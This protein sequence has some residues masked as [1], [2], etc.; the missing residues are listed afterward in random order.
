MKADADLLTPVVDL[1]RRGLFLQAYAASEP[2]GPPESWEGTEARIWAG[3]LAN[4]L[5][6]PQLGRVLH[7]LAWRDD[8]DNC[9]ARYFYA[10]SIFH[11]RGPWAAW[12]RMRRMSPLTNATST[13]LADWCALEAHL[14]AIFR[15]FQKADW[16]IAEAIDLAPDRAWVWIER[17]VVLDAE[18]RRDEALQSAERALELRPWY[19]AGVQATAHYLLQVN[20]DEE[21]LE[22]LRQAAQ[23]LECGDVVAHLASLETELGHFEE[24]R[25]HFNEVERFLPLLA[26]EKNRRKGL[27]AQRADAAYYCGDLEEAARLAAQVDEPFFRGFVER[28][29]SAPGEHRRVILPVGFVRQHHVTCAPATLAALSRYWSQPADHLEVAEKICY[30]GTPAHSQRQWAEENGFV[31]R[32]FRV[33]WETAVAL[34]DRGVPFALSTVGTGAA[35]LQAV[36]GYDTCRRSLLIRDPSE[37]HFTEFDADKLFEKLRSTGPGGMAMVPQEEAHRLDGLELPESDL[38]DEHYRIQRALQ[39]HDRQ[40]AGEIHARMSGNAPEHP[41]TLRASGALANYDADVIRALGEVERL[42]AIFPDDGNLLVFQLNCLRELGRREDRIALLESLCRKHDIDP[43]FYGR[44]A[45]ELAEDARNDAR[46]ERW[47]RRAM[48]YRPMEGAHFNLLADLF[49]NRQDRKEALSLYRIAACLDDKDE[50][51]TRAYFVAARCCRET[52][53]AMQL[54]RDRFTRFGRFSC[55][56]LR[57]LCWGFEQLEQTHEAFAVLKIAMELRPDDGEL[58]LFAADLHG[59]YGRYDEAAALLERAETCSHRTHWLRAAASLAMVRSDLPE[60]LRRWREVVEAEPLARDANECVAQLLADLEGPQAAELFLREAVGRFPHSNTLRVLLIEWLGNSQP[61]EA[62]VAV[63]ELLERHP[64]DP[65][66]RREL[67]VALARQQKWDEAMAEADLA[68]SLE[69]NH[70]TVHLIRARAKESQGKVS[71]A[72]EEYRRAIHISVDFEP[73]IDSLMATCDTRAQREEQLRF[74][75][76]EL[77]RQV[78]TGDGLLSYREHARGTVEP[79][80]LLA[81][82]QE[83]LRQRPDLWHA[84]AAVVRQLVELGRTDEALAVARAATER[85]PLLPRVWLELALAY[86]G[87]EDQQGEVESLRRALEINPSWSDA[88]HQLVETHRRRG[89]L[90]EAK[91]VLEQAVV[92]EPRNCQNHAVLADVLWETGERDEAV[93]RMLRAVRMEPGYPWPWTKLRQWATESEQ[94]DLALDPARELAETRP[95]EARSWIVLAQTL[96]HFERWEESLEAAERA[97]ALNPRHVESHGICVDCLVELG[98]YEEAAIHCRPEELGDPPPLELLGR[99]ADI[100]ARRGEIDSAVAQMRSVV[101]QDPDYFW[102]WSRLADWH[103]QRQENAEYL[104]A[105][106][107]MVRIAP[108]LPTCWGY[109]GDARRRGGD[110]AGA[111]A[112]FRRALEIAPDYVFATGSIFDMKLED[113]DVPGA[114]EALAALEPHVSPPLALAHRAR[115][116]ACAEDEAA[117]LGKLGELCHMSLD[118]ASPLGI[119]ISAALDKPWCD[120]VEGFLSEQLGQPDV[121]PHAATV[122]AELCAHRKQWHRCIRRLKA[123]AGCGEAWFYAAR[124]LMRDLGEAR[125]VQ[126][127]QR[128]VRKNRRRLRSDTRT[129]SAAGAVYFDWSRY[130]EAARWMSG[131]QAREGL[132]PSMLFPLVFSYWAKWRRGKAAAVARRALELPPDASTPYHHVLLALEESLGGDREQASARLGRLN[133]G[134]LT[135]FYQALYRLVEA[136]ASAPD[137]GE[138]AGYA[139]TAGRIRA[140]WLALP[141][142]QQKDPILRRVYRL[143]RWRAAKTHRRVVAAVFWYVAA[144]CS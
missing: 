4:A 34:V 19:V 140:A 31:A 135:K 144:R 68:E 57:T 80:S 138:S 27:L 113:R 132:E 64:V 8:P 123:I 73:A 33:D 118:D 116:E 49:W 92:R 71:E 66:A 22:L 110:R 20:R 107:Q 85:F 58:L 115:L 74:I 127:F 98:R 96:Q 89:D 78:I 90:P 83:A 77:V 6:A 32:E 24:A 21:A 101:E 59:R 10:L 119:A 53:T 2:L 48:R 121:S 37:R 97:I 23:R 136:A 40:A 38:Y 130:D 29:R 28:L 109:R 93:Q 62:E 72:R 43:L 54:L 128:F 94:P 3:R 67:A 13:T 36:I 56:P 76:E 124:Q 84:N 133:V 114:A 47:L 134:A 18:D 1:Y 5:G 122:W 88:V 141:E 51:R 117:Y 61:A 82:L 139:D 111:E 100:Q 79:E 106:E 69:P 39:V 131:W 99:E 26:R 70:P 50:G 105:A 46:A 86:R 30:D 129:W 42:L 103:D 52:A 125:E 65:W 11:R 143:C 35:H 41:L 44:Y 91:A 16:W 17:A 63:R 142:G 12:E 9:Q 45:A 104:A 7:R 75:Y 55:W 14:A 60:A 126:W 108:H 137:G 25:A 120:R 87:K 112:D 81:T 15:D 102:A 95:H